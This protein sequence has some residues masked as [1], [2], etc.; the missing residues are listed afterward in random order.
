MKWKVVAR[1]Q[2]QTDVLEA[3]VLHRESFAQ[4]AEIPDTA[5]CGCLQVLPT[6]EEVTPQ[7]NPPARQC[8]DRSSPTSS[9]R[10]Q[11]LKPYLVSLNK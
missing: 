2:A 1:P 7:L 10:T 11:L 9:H 8:G 5:V 4:K 3:A 6:D